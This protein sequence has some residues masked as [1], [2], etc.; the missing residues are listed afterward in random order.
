MKEELSLDR[1]AHVAAL[2]NSNCRSVLARVP[3]CASGWVRLVESTWQSAEHSHS[4]SVFASQ[5]MLPLSSFSK[6]RK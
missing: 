1:Q 3:H 6:T 5:C 4:F 2:G